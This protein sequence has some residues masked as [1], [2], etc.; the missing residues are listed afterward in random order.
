MEDLEDMKR[1]EEEMKALEMKRKMT[2]KE[3]EKMI[4]YKYI[5]LLGHEKE[6]KCYTLLKGA[7]CYIL[8]SGKIVNRLLFAT[9]LFLGYSQRR[10]FLK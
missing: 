5:N 3:E 6:Y 4:G 7:F 2:A 1:E 8:V 9:V 10:S